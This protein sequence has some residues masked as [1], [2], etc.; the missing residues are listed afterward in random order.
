[1][2]QSFQQPWPDLFEGRITVA[3]KL[4]QPAA[5]PSM[6]KASVMADVI[7]A[8]GNCMAG[9]PIPACFGQVMADISKALPDATLHPVDQAFASAE[10]YLKEAGL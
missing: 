9:S 3:E 7:C 5:H 6:N 4:A 2:N 10:R 1:M 8:W